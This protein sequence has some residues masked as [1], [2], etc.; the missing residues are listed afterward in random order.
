MGKLVEDFKTNNADDVFFL[1]GMGK[2]QIVS[3]QIFGFIHVVHPRG[4]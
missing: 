4:S 1:E 2:G 3:M